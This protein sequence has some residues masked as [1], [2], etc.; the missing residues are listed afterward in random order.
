[1]A[2]IPPKLKQA[3]RSSDPEIRERAARELAELPGPISISL[4]KELVCDDDPD[5]VHA[6]SRSIRKIGAR[7]ATQ[8]LV[9]LLRSDNARHRNRAAIL[10]ACLGPDALPQ[11]ANLLVDPDGDIRK[12]GVDII[13]DMALPESE[14]ILVKALYDDS[15][16]VAVAAAESL[17]KVGGPGAVPYLAECLQKAPW[18]KCAAMKALARIGGDEA[19]SAILKTSLDEESIV[20]FSAVSALG[21]MG[22]ARGIDFL[23]RLLDCGLSMLEP[24][25]AQAL[26]SILKNA[27]G[28]KLERVREKLSAERIAGLLD[29]GNSEVVRSAVALL[30]RLGD[31]S[32]VPGLAR[33]FRADNAHLFEELEKA[34]LAIDPSD[35]SPVASILSDDREPETV[36]IA[37]IRLLGKTKRS[38]AFE[39]LAVFLEAC[40]EE[41]KPYVLQAMAET[42]DP[43]GVS[44]FHR[45]LRSGGESVCL[46]AVEALQRHASPESIPHLTALAQGPS[47]P[48]RKA[49]A[50]S[51]KKYGG[52][53]KHAPVLD[54][55][56]SESPDTVAF[57]LDMLDASSALLFR[58]EITR[59]CASPEGRIRRRAVKKTALLKDPASYA[60]VRRAL[61]DQD[62]LV[63]LAAIRGLAHFP[64][65]DTQEILVQTACGDPKDW[66]RYEALE[67]LNASE[68]IENM[69]PVLSLL[70][71]G[72]ALVKTAA[73][74]ILG[75]HGNREHLEMLE[76][77]AD[78]PSELVK[79]A[80]F[81]AMERMSE[82]F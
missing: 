82:R 44:Y 69:G 4:L 74:D 49:A 7:A 78:S 14:N 32:N 37:A 56:R 52:I 65:P 40:A 3:A 64:G 54:M 22:D 30:G 24:A 5:V 81:E 29:H 42:Q 39:A 6:A 46:A 2:F 10:I 26:A 50:A 13:R 8:P 17:G 31:E 1:M 47:S 62:E 19:L 35:V 63:R 28:K 61:S 72:S 80:A 15:V 41:L 66:N 27:D 60:E 68:N 23:L 57:A 77:Y 51:L 71:S 79:D 75:K 12:F 67:V 20:L 73:L 53:E 33:L 16:N 25:V 38:E 59:L 18:L 45:M 9:D 11:V 76:P 55:L 21:T 70:Q 58:D 36:K 48:V 34:L 43:R